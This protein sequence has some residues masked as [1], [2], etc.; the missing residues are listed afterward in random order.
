MDYKKLKTSLLK[1]FHMTEDG[2]KKKFHGTKM[3]KGGTAAQLMA[4]LKDH[5]DRW[6][7]L[8][9]VETTYEG[10]HDFIIIEQFLHSSPDEIS[11]HVREKE[12]RTIDEV[13][14]AAEIYMDA[15]KLGVGS[16]KSRG[17]KSDALVGNRQPTSL[18]RRFDNT[19]NTVDVK[20]GHP[21]L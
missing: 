8:A 16:F 1:H 21:S 19:G 14:H 17:S 20:K 10:I 18:N 6:I 2:F 7:E 3:E 15:H 9:E 5:F 11:V 12:L 4:K 13:V